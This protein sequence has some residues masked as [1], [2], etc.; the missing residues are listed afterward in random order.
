VSLKNHAVTI[1]YGA[2]VL[3]LSPM[4]RVTGLNKEKLGAIPTGVYLKPD[5]IS[6]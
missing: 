1:S 5:V 4:E 6:K 3:V 2:E